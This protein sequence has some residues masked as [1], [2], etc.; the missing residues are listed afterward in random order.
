MKEWSVYGLRWRKSMNSEKQF[1]A[2]IRPHCLELNRCNQRGGRMLSI[3][4]LVEAGSLDVTLAAYL[5]K[6]MTEGASLLVGA[7]PGGAGK[8]TVMCALL[9]LGPADCRLKP[10]TSE[11]L[12]RITHAGDLAEGER[13]CLV[14][15]EIGSGSYYGYLWGRDLRVYCSLGGKGRI[16]A[17]NLHADDLDEARE[18]IC[19]T[20]GVR[21]PD[22]NKFDLILFLRMGYGRAGYRRWID[23]VY[24][25]DG[26]SV[27]ALIFDAE[28]GWSPTVSFQDE[29]LLSF[30]GFI[31]G[32]LSQG[33]CMVED[34]RL[35]ALKF[36]EC[37]R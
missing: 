1:D 26:S 16:L 12:S 25:S 34:A 32:G 29:Q 24:S 19:D 37:S 18:Q 10:A 4:D 35:K 15:H 5:M 33:V 28:R 22:F 8:T 7:R 14:C 27:H 13:E 9:N 6:R 31:E 17:A 20:N 3:F 30:R 11:N 2:E 23:K 36:Q 21:I